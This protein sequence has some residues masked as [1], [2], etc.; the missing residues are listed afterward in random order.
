MVIP[1]N[2]SFPC[3]SYL[4]EKLTKSRKQMLFYNNFSYELDGTYTFSFS[5]RFPNIIITSSIKVFSHCTKEQNLACCVISIQNQPTNSTC[6]FLLWLL[7][8]IIYGVCL[9]QKAMEL[10]TDSF[11]FLH[12]LGVQTNKR[13]NTL[14]V[15]WNRLK[16][17]LKFWFLRFWWEKFG[18]YWDLI[19]KWS[20]S[21]LQ[22][23]R[24]YL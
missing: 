19:G 13:K 12:F 10:N 18:G 9:A 7:N 11:S 17:Y 22:W 2:G 4:K 21:L 15:C 20:C 6:T 1:K 16:G 24:N 3:F 23:P 8:M 5:F 14:Q